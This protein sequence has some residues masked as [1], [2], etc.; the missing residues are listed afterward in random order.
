MRSLFRTE[1]KTQVKLESANIESFVPTYS[2][3]VEKRGQ[4]SLVEAPVV[5]N[6]IFV[7][8]TPEELQPFVEAD[9]RFQ[10]LYVKGGRQ[11]ERMVV[12]EVAMQH[13]IRVVRSAQKPMFF[14]PSALDVSKGARVRLLGGPLDG[15]EGRFMRVKGARSRCLVVIIPDTM[16]VAAEVTADLV[17][18]ID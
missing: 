15:V 5:S 12:E 17:E 10:Y 7:H 6:L 14:S 8:S 11:N 13:F 1:L 2:R 9:S 16:A 3:I 18:V 4:K